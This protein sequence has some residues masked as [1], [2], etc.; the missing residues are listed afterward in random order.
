MDFLDTPEQAFYRARV[1]QWLSEQ[2]PACEVHAEEELSEERFMAR[3]R[4]W[5]ALKYDAGFVGIMWPKAVGGQGSSPIEHVIFHQ[6]EEAF[7]MP[8][9]PF[10]VGIGMCLPTLFTHGSAE[11]V[12]RFMAPGMRGEEIW[13]QL[14]SEPAAGSDLAGLR[15][16][17]VRDD[18]HWVLNGQKVW[19]SYAHEADYGIVL[20][21][22][23]P[24][25]P[26]HKGLTMFY[27]DMRAPGV[28]V[29]QIRTL[30]G[31]A[32]FNEV[33]FT[34]VRIP[35][36][37]RLGAVGDGWK[38]SLSTLMFERLAVGGKPAGAPDARDLLAQGLVG[39]EQAEAL[40]RFYVAD[41]GIAL[42]RLRSMTA[43]SRGGVPGPEASIN[44]LVMA[45]TL[46]DMSGYALEQL[47]ADGLREF[48]DP[49]ARR[50][51]Y[52]YLW[53]AG[54]RIAGG[55]DEILRNIIAERVLGL[56]AELRND[57][58]TPFNQL[59]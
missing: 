51:N 47:G 21:R 52:W 58:D 25:Q 53:S 8:N 20:V 31:D 40:A 26:K 34:D 49:R 50:Y 4:A 24:S 54:L 55:T 6:E 28:E 22:T 13:C 7:S 30:L 32:E 43:V 37:Q 1:R 45:K 36:S 14:F 59:S 39:P 19:T 38:V 16:R 5:Q 44:K 2:A 41:E 56:P 23:D 11:V 33:F 17:A 27:V 15:T 48:D 42:T 57:R 9:V 46:Q 10:A 18:D 3:A 35:D 29:R 12:E